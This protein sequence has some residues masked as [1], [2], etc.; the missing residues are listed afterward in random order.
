MKR[1]LL[2]HGPNLNLLGS[3]DPAIYGRDTLA[4]VVARVERAA[5]ATD[6]EIH[7][8]QSNHEGALIDEIQARRA[9]AAG[10]LVNLGAFTHSSYA[11]HDALV[12]FAKPVVEVHLSKISE[13]ESWRR[14]SV[15]RPACIGFVEGKGAAGYEEALRILVEALR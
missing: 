14:Q 15:I 8:F 9:W 3:R 12:D 6:V 11:L 7:A 13:R 10:A 4:D 5:A 1:V 2:L